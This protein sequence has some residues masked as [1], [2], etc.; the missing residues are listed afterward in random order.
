MRQVCLLL[1]LL[2]GGCTS[3]EK[4]PAGIEGNQSLSVEERSAMQTTRIFFGHQS[5]G[6]DILAGITEFEPELRVVTAA[7]PGRIEGPALIEASIGRNGDPRSKDHAFLEAA[8]K[9]GPDDVATYKYCYADMLAETDPD[10][11]FAQYQGTLDTAARSGVRTIAITMPLTT[12]AP[13]WKRWIKQV[14]G[15]TTDLELNA[16]RQRF[17]ELL[18]QSGTDRPLIDLARLE[19]TLE[20]GIQR[21]A[22]FKGQTLGILASEYTN[23]GAHLNDRGRRQVAPQ[24]LRALSR[25]ASAD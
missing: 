7:D 17:N 25:V 2:S 15:K 9:L 10:S 18:R 4:D 16:K 14:L 6:R 20:D 19:S 5:V 23:D 11:L 3:G 13:A 8:S 1:L 24:F 12:V 22:S 21:T